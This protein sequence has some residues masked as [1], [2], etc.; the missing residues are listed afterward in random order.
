MRRQYL[1]LKDQ[2]PDA[3][4]FFRLGDFYETFDQDAETCARVLQITLTGREIGRGQRVP[5]AGVPANAVQG[6]LARMVQAGFKVAV[7]EQVG[8]TEPAASGARAMM[9]REVTRVV[10]AGTVIE[11]SML[12]G[13]RNNYLV[14]VVASSATDDRKVK[15]GI[16]DER[17]RALSWGLAYADITTGEFG[18]AQ[19]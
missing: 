19:L 12:D 10:T 13:R 15:R 4:L 1:S 17:G 14:S 16:P 11:P 5:M 7:C 9:S 6:Y 3:I 18:C 8:E 2:H